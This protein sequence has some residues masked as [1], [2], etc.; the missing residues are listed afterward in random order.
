MW[1]GLLPSMLVLF[2]ASFYLSDLSEILAKSPSL[3]IS[4]VSIWVHFS[5]ELPL[6]HSR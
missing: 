4:Q 6:R 5:S 3:K 1:F 2:S